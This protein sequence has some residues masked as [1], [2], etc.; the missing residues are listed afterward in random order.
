MLGSTDHDRP[1]TTHDG[2]GRQTLLVA[3]LF[4][5][6]TLLAT[7]PIVSAPNRYAYFDHPDTQLN[8][9]IMAWDAHA[10]GHDPRQLFN[11]NIF[12]PEP[13]TLVYSETLLGYLPVFGP[14]LWLHGSPVLAFNVVLLVSFAA[15]GFGMY[16]LARHLTGRHWPAIVAGIV[17]AFLPYRFVHVPQIQLEAMEWLPLAFLCLHLFVERGAPKH[18]FA[19]SACIVMGTLC[20]VYYGIF[21]VTALTIAT[22]VLV[23][24]DRRARTPRALATLVA[25]GCLA[26]L[27]LAPVIGEYLHVHHQIGLE[28]PL[29]EITAKSADANSY[30]ASGAPVHQAL[31]GSP[32]AAPQELLHPPPMMPHDYLFPGFLALLLAA[33]GL[34][35]SHRRGVVFIYLAVGAFGLA[36]SFGPAG[37]MGISIYRPLYRLIPIFHGLRQI[38]RFGVLTLF[39]VSVLGA[40]ACA[41]LEPEL[42][43]RHRELWM[44]AIATLV[45]L[46]TFSAP[47]R[48]DFP[49]GTP[50]VRSPDPPPVYTWLAQQPGRFSIVE[51]PMA[52]YGELYRNAPYVYWSTVHWHPLV[53][54]Y[55]GFAPPN[56]ASFGRVFRNFPDKLSHEA[57]DVHGTRYVIVHWDRWIPSDPWID[58]ARLNRC[59]WLRRVVQFPNVDV[60]EVL[61]GDRQLTGANR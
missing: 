12:F 16:L 13:R 17:Y 55:S 48:Y 32:I 56:Y 57:L 46:E 14:I 50:L 49:G 4:V 24:T 34:V 45:F 27:L 39:A 26:G 37:L 2:P 30:L 40:F 47:L 52:H 9:W 18:A 19:L 53:N 58:A 20:C 41:A 51:L 6:L 29:E 1:I 38:S 7:Y 43:A 8:M 25:A 5:V 44:F 42:P 60:Y 15:S 28:R 11:A 10:L 33:A 22:A 36:A 54:G 31:L 35:T 3:V 59:A 21:L 23:V 61:P